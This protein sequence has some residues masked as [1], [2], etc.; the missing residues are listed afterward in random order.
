[1]GVVLIDTKKVNRGVM[2]PVAYTTV[3]VLGIWPIFYLSF[4]ISQYIY[5][6]HI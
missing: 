1:M 4:L 5:H 2:F 3:D 6:F